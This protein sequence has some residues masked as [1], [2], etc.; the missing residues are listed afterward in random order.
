MTPTKSYFRIIAGKGSM[1]AQACFEHGFIGCDWLDNIDLTDKLPENWRE[2]N[3]DMIPIY[4]ESNPDKSKVSAGLACGMMHTICKGIKVGDIVFCPNGQGIYFVGEVTSE[5]VY[6]SNEVLPHR[7]LVKWYG[8]GVAREEMSKPLKNSTGSVG[9]VSNI[10]K[11]AEELEALLE[12]KAPPALTHSDATV[13][14]PSVFALEKH[15][16]D[17]LVANWAS[18]DLGREF[19]IYTDEGEIVGQQYQSDTGPIDILAISKDKKTLLVV[20]LKRGRASDNVVG[21]IQRYMGYVKDE[22]CEQ[23]QTVK[24]IIIALEDD[25]RIKRALSVTNNIDFYRYQV[26]FRLEK[27]Q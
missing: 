6:R 2:F 7:R 27:Q 15:L 1:H 17:F 8:K 10:T 4:L 21:Q 14:D 3:H 23:G 12:G 25:I 26:S 5:Y 16:E 9:T 20:E 24:G 22:L 13:E 11:Y 19:D 18:T